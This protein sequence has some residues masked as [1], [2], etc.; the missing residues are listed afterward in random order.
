MTKKQQLRHYNLEKA[1]EVVSAKSTQKE[2]LLKAVKLLKSLLA[3]V[4]PVVRHAMA[5]FSL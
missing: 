3:N 4:F 1:E 2:E 5:L